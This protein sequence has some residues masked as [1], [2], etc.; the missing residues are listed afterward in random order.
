[1]STSNNA[2]VT[3]PGTLD[4]DFGI[5][6]VEVLQEILKD[7]GD[8]TVRYRFKGLATAVDGKL[9]FSASLY[10]DGDDHYVYGLGRLNADGSLDK[11]FGT[12]GLATGDFLPS[13]PAGGSRLAVKSAG[14]ILM[15]GWT[16]RNASNGWADLVV[17]RFNSEGKLDISFAEQGRCILPTRDHEELTEDSATVHVQGD[18][19]ILVSANYS[20]RGNL[21]QTVGVLYR[22]L[23]DGALDA[24]FNGN[25]KLEFKLPDPDAA[26]AINAC[27]S[28]GSDHKIVFVG[29]ARFIP[30]LKTA[31]FARL[32]SDGTPDTGFGSPKT[33]GLH[34][35]DS[36]KDH[37]TFN[38]LIK[39][40]DNSLVGAGQVG[41][42][43][44]EST[45]GL[46]R[47]ITPEGAVHQLFNNGNPLLSQF[48]SNHDNGWQCIMQTRAGHLVTASTGNWI[49]IAQFNADGTLNSAFNN[50]GYN[51]MQSGPRSSPVLLTERGDQRV[52][53]GANVLGFDPDGV[54]QL[55]CFF[56]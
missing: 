39:R 55:R 11:S 50:K 25:G 7:H 38:A 33:P 20:T 48:D 1:M 30:D 45:R 9:L 14:N 2:S 41:L 5:D 6:G 18:G 17:A 13:V 23:P 32:N 15:L 44:A 52:I 4:P 43:G 22:L 37:A 26:T 10:R 46:M 42:N 12:N 27:I 19:R 51:D 56:G 34:R 49:Y 31:L 29:H 16:W 35:M 24:S 54:G 47:A 3:H 28:Q 40:V 21:E 8:F 53:A 36:I